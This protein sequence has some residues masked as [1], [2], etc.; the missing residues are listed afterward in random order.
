MD[1]RGLLASAWEFLREF[2]ER[3]AIRPKALM[4]L[5]VFYID[6][7]GHNKK[8]C[9]GL[10]ASHSKTGLEKVT[11]H[12]SHSRK[13]FPNTLYVPATCVEL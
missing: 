12:E 7:V 6:S 10:S 3:V 11:V 13:P 4:A 8:H 1:G 5:P 9:K 2:A